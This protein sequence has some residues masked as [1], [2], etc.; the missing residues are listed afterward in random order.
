MKTKFYSS[1]I[2]TTFYCATLSAQTNTFPSTGAAGIGTV[3]PN[4]SSLLEIKSTSKGILISRMTQA[5]RNAI[6]SP[7]TG[8]MIYQTNNTPGFYYYSGTKWTAVTTKSKGWSLTGNAGTSP[9]TNFI[10][11]TDAQPLI[12]KIN[13][14]KGGYIDFDD[15]KANTG[16]GYQT[17]FSNPT[18]FNNTANGYRALYSNSTG[19]GNTANGFKALYSNT[20]GYQN[21]ANGVNALT[22]NNT[23]YANT[24]TGVQTLF[25]NTSG[26][27]NVAVGIKALYRNTSK[28]NK[29]A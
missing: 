16:F 6:V 22:K 11:T 9:G 15:A 23:G 24:A 4:A 27:S 5:Q 14:N 17:F 21:T 28:S 29:K 10:G 1:V 19:Y 13:N 8:L 2:A 26:Y 18:G 3:T 12:F 7:A 25:S 20:T